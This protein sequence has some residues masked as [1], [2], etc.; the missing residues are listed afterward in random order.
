MHFAALML[1]AALSSAR[2]DAKIEAYG[3]LPADTRD[4]AGDTIGGIGSALVCIPKTDLFLCLSDRGP[5]DGS[6]AYRPRL[7]ILRIVQ[8]GVQ[9]ETTLVETV[10]LRDKEGREMT[11]LIPDDPE[12][13][14]PRLKDGRTCIDP[15]GLALAPDGTIYV[16]EEYGPAIYQFTSEGRMIRRIALPEMFRPVTREGKSDFTDRAQLVGGRNINQGPEGLCLLPGGETAAVILQSGLV[17]YGGQRSATTW[18]VLLDL[19]TEKPVAIYSYPFTD[20]TPETDAPLRIT[21]LSVNDLAALSDTKF[22]ALERDRAGRNGALDPHPPRL[23]SV[24]LVETAGAGNL[25]ESKEP[26]PVKKTLLFNLPDLVPDPSRLAAKW[27]GI[28]VLPGS[29]EREI[30][31][32]MSA[33][34][35]FLTPVIHEAGEERRFPRAQDSVPTQFYKIRVSLPE[36]P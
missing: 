25:L 12:S 31:L 36:N 35:D 33:D 22:L 32:L 34:N 5:G 10:I 16:S 4:A 19:K 21:H 3:E 29:N 24:W 26:A 15:E 20:R 1:A 7:A 6:I 27:E 11:G 18:L 2:A 23:K 14:I 30:T 17:Q 9:L 8:N 13:A 28:A